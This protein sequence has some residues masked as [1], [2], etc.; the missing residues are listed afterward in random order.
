MENLSQGNRMALDCLAPNEIR[1]VDLPIMG[2]GLDWPAASCHPWLSCQVTGQPSVSLSFCR[3]AIIRG[4]LH[5][6]TLSQ[7]SRSGL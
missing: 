7:S 4:S 5:Q 2:Y 6:L 1:F 3:V